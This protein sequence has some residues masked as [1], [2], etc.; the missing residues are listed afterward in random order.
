[1][2][3]KTIAYII[4]VVFMA[5]GGYIGGGSDYA[6]GLAVGGLAAVLLFPL[7]HDRVGKMFGLEPNE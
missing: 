7:V 1:M 3:K 2:D 6:L 4:Y 5:G